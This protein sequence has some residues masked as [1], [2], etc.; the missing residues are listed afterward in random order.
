[1]FSTD[2]SKPERQGKCYGAGAWVNG[3]INP[4]KSKSHS[5]LNKLVF[6]LGLNA[7]TCMGIESGEKV[8]RSSIKL[9]QKVNDQQ[10]IVKSWLEISSFKCLK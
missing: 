3:A 2:K 6:D 9:M 5:K 10:M 7:D 1:M 4:A 8:D